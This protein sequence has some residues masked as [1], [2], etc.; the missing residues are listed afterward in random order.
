[1]HRSW[2]PGVLAVVLAS[3][4]L[5][6]CT[7]DPQ[8]QPLPS[9]SVTS[10]P[11]AELSAYYDQKLSWSGCG[12]SFECTSL[13]VPR[14]WKQPG[15]G[16][17]QVAVIRLPASDPDQRI[18]SLLINP[19]GPGV[20][21]VE[22]ARAARAQITAPVR[23]T[24]DIVGFDPRGAGETSPVRCLPAPQ[25]DDYFSADPTPDDSA[26][27][28]SFV[29]AI[30]T[31]TH[32]CEQRSG[33]ILPYVS[34]EDTARDMDVLR[35][36]LGDERLAYLGASYGTYLGAVYAGLFPERVGRLVLD[37]AMD[38]S[39]D[40]IETGK[41]QLQGFQQAFDS[42][43][44]DCAEHD[45]CPL[46]ADRAA[47]GQ[48]MAAFFDELDA[49]PIPTHD[50]ARPLTEGLATLGVGEA[51]YAPEY[52]WEPLRAGL[53]QAFHGD[54]SVLL[55]L[56][57]LY[58]NRNQDGSYGN[59]LEANLA[60]NCLDKGSLK[61]VGDAE[62]LVPDYEQVSPVF[63]AG[64][65]WSTISCRDWPYPPVAPSEP[66]TAPGAAPIL[67]VGTT[68]DPATPYAWAQALADQLQS[69][70]L[71][72]FDGDGHTAYNRGSSCVNRAVEAYLVGGQVPD[73]GTTCS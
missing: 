39:L 16:D 35:A 68:R 50:P 47:A 41:Q 65:A 27:E 32:G 36:A 28:K 48:R 15:N 72:T 46:P 60:I 13:T 22:Y 14:D 38:P 5:A 57:D 29:G 9:A 67:V 40:G 18:G 26:E 2:L 20:S 44:A 64:F 43:V 4:A 19:G 70:V 69:G 73:D 24:Y 30:A 66:I 52:F 63:G 54:G 31:M 59:L 8:P 33:A 17:L 25:L 34:T 49:R 6:G 56:A 12:G 71:L 7:S 45:D 58:T 53:T 42:F 55:Q 3:A 11:P 37:G 61:T 23:N 62:R 10:Q 51:L 21:G 1:M